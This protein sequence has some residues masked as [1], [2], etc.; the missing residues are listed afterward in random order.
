VPIICEYPF[1]HIKSEHIK[2]GISLPVHRHASCHELCGGQHGGHAVEEEGILLCEYVYVCVIYTHKPFAWYMN[3][4]VCVVVSA[5]MHA[6]VF[7]CVNTFVSMHFIDR[8]V[9]PIET[10][11]GEAA[12]QAYILLN[13]E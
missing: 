9:A 8:C 10:Q 6:Y 5:F 13:S 1:E 3:T 12:H 11:I 4:H 2:S 7:I